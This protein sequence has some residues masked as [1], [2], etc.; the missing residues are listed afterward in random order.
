MGLK[1]GEQRVSAAV[2]PMSRLKVLCEGR[3]DA[4]YQ[5]GIYCFLEWSTTRTS[6]GLIMQVSENVSKDIVANVFQGGNRVAANHKPHAVGRQGKPEDISQGVKPVKS[7]PWHRDD[8]K[9]QLN[10]T[11]GH[12]KTQRRKPTNRT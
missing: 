10:Q 11:F 5:A 8:R 3:D 4:F 12:L 1:L 2:L 6:N 9:Y 7:R